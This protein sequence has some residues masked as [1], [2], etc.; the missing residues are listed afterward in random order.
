MSS[1]SYVSPKTALEFLLMT[2]LG[3]RRAARYVGVPPNTLYR[4]LRSDS[5]FPFREA[6]IVKF[7]SAYFRRKAEVENDLRIREELGL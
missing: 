6:T 7:Q 1:N 2:G 3:K 4:V 5:D